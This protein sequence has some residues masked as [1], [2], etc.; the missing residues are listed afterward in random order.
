M[1]GNLQDISLFYFKHDNAMK[2]F[3]LSNRLRFSTTGCWLKIQG[4]YLVGRD[5][6]NVSLLLL[7]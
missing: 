1:H 3:K 2:V 4:L 5:G 7:F 6:P